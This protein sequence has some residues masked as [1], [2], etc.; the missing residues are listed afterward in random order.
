MNYK[1]TAVIYQREKYFKRFKTL[2]L[3]EVNEKCFEYSHI[4]VSLYFICYL[5]INIINAYYICI[6]NISLHLREYP[7]GGMVKAM[8]CESKLQSCYYIHFQ[9]N[10]LGKG[11]NP[12]I[13]P[14]MG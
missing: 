4:L 13:L 7:R 10:T 2:N 11:M 14:A 9:T 3:S 5:Y 6:F 12:L 1:Y 8:D